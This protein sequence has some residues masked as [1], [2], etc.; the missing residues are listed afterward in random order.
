MTPQRPVEPTLMINP[1]GA[2][3]RN[4]FE[5]C[6]ALEAAIDTDDE[7]AWILLAKLG[8]SQI[9]DVTKDADR[10]SVMPRSTT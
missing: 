8:V 5:F 4:R 3:R 10:S 7:A 2:W 1:A 6:N 9:R